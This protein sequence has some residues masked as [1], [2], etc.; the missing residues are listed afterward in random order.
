M[1]IKKRNEI[2]FEGRVIFEPRTK[3]FGNGKVLQE[4]GMGVY[5]GKNEDGSYKNANVIVK[6]WGNSCP[7]KGQDIIVTGRLGAEVWSKDGKDQSKITIVCESF[8]VAGQAK[9]APQAQAPQG[10]DLPF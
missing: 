1:E 7:A 2:I 8:D 3:T 4:W 5:A 9:S 10:D 6:H